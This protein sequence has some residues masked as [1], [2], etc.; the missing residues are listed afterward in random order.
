MN[1]IFYSSI[2]YNTKLKFGLNFNKIYIFYYIINSIIII[3]L[4]IL[5][6]FTILLYNLFINNDIYFLLSNLSIDLITLDA[7]PIEVGA[8]VTVSTIVFGI[9]LE[10]ISPLATL[11]SSTGSILKL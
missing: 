6:L 7:L 1:I 5:I 9:K 11:V 8:T 10:T 4:I 3:L 2:I